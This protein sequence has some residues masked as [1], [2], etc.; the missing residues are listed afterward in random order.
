MF[1]QKVSDSVDIFK[2]NVFI[3]RVS[4]ETRKESYHS[5]G[6]MSDHVH[7]PEGSPVTS[8]RRGIWNSFIFV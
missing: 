1:L 7:S 4:E 3:D 8:P 5:N 6:S 2:E